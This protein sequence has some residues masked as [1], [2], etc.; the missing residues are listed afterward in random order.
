[1]PD[2]VTRDTAQQMHYAAYRYHQTHGRAEAAWW[3]ERYYQLRDRIILGN[4][5]LVFRASP[6]ALADRRGRRPDRRVLRG[7][8]AGSGGVQSLA[9]R[10]VQHMRTPA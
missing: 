2:E 6:L 7:P 3:K 1:M 9:G 10:A 4:R 5:K 8:A